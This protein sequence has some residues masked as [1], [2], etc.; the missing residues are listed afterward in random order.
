MIMKECP[1]CEKELLELLHDIR[2]SRGA[3]MTAG[4]HHPRS[5]G[6]G[7]GDAKPAM[8]IGGNKK[9]KTGSSWS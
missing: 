4:T 9:K 3:C 6:Q 5:A 1:L 8:P 7:Q 2:L